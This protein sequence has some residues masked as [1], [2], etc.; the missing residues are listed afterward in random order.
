MV[1]TLE[2]ELYNME[3]YT[4]KKWKNAILRGIRGPTIKNPENIFHWRCGYTASQPANTG[5]FVYT[6]LN[7]AAKLHGELHI[8]SIS[9][10]F[11]I[12]TSKVEN[13]KLYLTV[14]S[15]DYFQQHVVKKFFQ[16]WRKLQKKKKINDAS[17]IVY[18]DI[19]MPKSS[20]YR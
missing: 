18:G 20:F 7:N 12:T 4:Q 8:S 17:C 6:F 3:R 19:V 9:S 5:I 16:K 15:L 11:G 2:Q 10:T 14:L 1:T 13:Y